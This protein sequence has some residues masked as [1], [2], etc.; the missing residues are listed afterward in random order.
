MS[1]RRS[2]QEDSAWIEWTGG[3]RPVRDDVK[4]DAKFRRG[5]EVNGLEAG[6][7]RWNHSH[8]SDRRERPSDIVAYRV[9]GVAA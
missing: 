8:P 1:E 7:W 3:E 2:P 9:V 5:N 6:F 4:V